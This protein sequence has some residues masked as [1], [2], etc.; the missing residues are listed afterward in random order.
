MVAALAAAQG[1]V[2]HARCA[3]GDEWAPVEVRLFVDNAVV[4]RSLVKGSCRAPD[5]NAAVQAFWEWAARGEVLIGIFRVP[6]K[7]N[8]ADGPSRRDFAWTTARQSLPAK[9]PAALDEVAHRML[10]FL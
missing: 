1:A 4:E 9:P 8:P 3:A 7:A 6:S 2:E 10:P 5:L